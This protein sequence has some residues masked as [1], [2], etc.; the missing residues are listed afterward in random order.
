MPALTCTEAINLACKLPSRGKLRCKKLHCKD[1]GR[2]LCPVCKQHY[3][4]MIFSEDPEGCSTNC[5]KITHNDTAP[6]QP[7]GVKAV[8]E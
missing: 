8:V 4:V 5:V 7:P 6:W 3:K 1:C 2:H